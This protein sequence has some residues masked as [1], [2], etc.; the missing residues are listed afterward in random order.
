MDILANEFRVICD[1]IREQLLI[2][3]VQR[4]IGKTDKTGKIEEIN[5]ARKKNVSR[6]QKGRIRVGKIKGRFES[7]CKYPITKGY[8]NIIVCSVNKTKLGSE[9]TPF[10]LTNSRGQIMEN[11][12]QFSKV[13]ATVSKINA[14]SGWSWPS[15]I[16][17]HQGEIT[18]DYWQWRIAGMNFMS[19]I[20]SPVPATDR[21]KCCYSL[22]PSDAMGINMTE[23]YISNISDADPKNMIQ[24]SYLEARQNVYCPLYTN[25][26]KQQDQFRILKILLEA[27]YNLQIL[28]LDGPNK[29]DI[30]PYNE[31]VDGS[32]GEDKVGSISIN[33]KNIGLLLKYIMQPFGHGYVLAVALMGKEHWLF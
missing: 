11:I 15:Q 12:W 8:I 1:E 32:Y 21:A 2:N 13:Y 19:P 9:L 28:D 4:E 3:I 10:L 20:R 27:G 25:L 6:N 22:W 33:K 18:D 7:G 24:L 30:P 29:E 5:A 17:V 26:V 14:P 16:H 31:M 23:N